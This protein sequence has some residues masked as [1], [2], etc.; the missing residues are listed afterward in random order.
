[1]TERTD[2]DTSAAPAPPA[3]LHAGFLALLPRLLACAEYAFRHRRGA[4][5][6]D[7]VAEVLALCWRWYA[8]LAQRGKDPHAY[9]TALA[10]FAGRWVRGGRG[11]CGLRGTKDALSRLARARHGFAV[12]PLPQ[13]GGRDATGLEEAL[14]D[15]TQTPVPEQVSFRLDFPEWRGS[16]PDRDRRLIDDLMAGERV[17]DV[18]GK[19]GLTPGRVSQLR[20]AFHDDWRRFCGETAED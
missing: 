16:L 15:N 7:A 9:P 3:A 6:D 13:A 19:Y 17:L 11:L 18:A 2:T 5:R 14:H 1:M 10:D 8:R 12:V 4:D 20:R